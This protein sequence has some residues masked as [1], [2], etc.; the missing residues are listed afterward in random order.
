MARRRRS[1]PRRPPVLTPGRVI[2]GAPIGRVARARY[3]SL[4]RSSSLPVATWARPGGIPRRPLRPPILIRSGVVRHRVPRA[5][6]SLRSIGSMR[7]DGRVMRGLPPGPC[8]GRQTT[9]EVLFANGVA[10][11]RWG[12]GGGP[13]P[14]AMRLKS[15]RP[16]K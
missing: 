14:E 5:I 1:S 2:R 15:S 12:S 10:G 6:R 9:K 7:L 3:W 8:P 16:C 11:R 4:P 13:S